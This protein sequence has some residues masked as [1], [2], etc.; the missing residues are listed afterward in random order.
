MIR[1]GGFSLDDDR[2]RIGDIKRRIDDLNDILASAYSVGLSVDIK[3]SPERDGPGGQCKLTLTTAGR[4]YVS[5]RD[6]TPEF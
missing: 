2:I 3:V 5:P 4:M 1:T 6:L